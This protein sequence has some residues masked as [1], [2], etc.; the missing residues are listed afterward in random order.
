V[1]I[2]LNMM[3]PNTACKAVV[4][5][6]ILTIIMQHGES[7]DEADLIQEQA[8]SS[9][10]LRSGANTLNLIEKDAMRKAG[11]EMQPESGRS[12]FLKTGISVS[13]S[14]EENVDTSASDL[15][16]ELVADRKQLLQRNLET[17]HL[18]E[19][20]EHESAARKVLEGVIGSRSQEQK[21]FYSYMS[22]WWRLHR[23]W[24]KRHNVRLYEKLREHRALSISTLWKPFLLRWHYVQPRLLQG[25]RYDWNK[26][27]TYRTKRFL[28][29]STKKTDKRIVAARI[30][31]VNNVCFPGLLTP[32]R[33]NKSCT[34]NKRVSARA[35]QFTVERGKFEAP[36]LTVMRAYTTYVPK[37][38][39]Q[40]SHIDTNKWTKAKPAIAFVSVQGLHW[41]ILQVLEYCDVPRS[42]IGGVGVPLP[43][44]PT[45][46]SP[47]RAYSLKLMEWKPM[48]MG[49]ELLDTGATVE[50]I[51][52]S[53]ADGKLRI[54]CVIPVSH[55]QDVDGEEVKLSAQKCSIYLRQW[56]FNLKCPVGK[57]GALA[58]KT[59]VTARDD[60]GSGNGKASITPAFQS[61]LT[62]DKNR[63]SLK[64]EKQAV[65]HIHD[66]KTNADARSSVPVVMT[67]PDKMQFTADSRYKTSRSLYFS[68]I[69]ADAQKVKDGILT[70]DPEME[71][72]FTSSPKKL[73]AQAERATVSSLSKT[74]SVPVDIS[75]SAF[76]QLDAIPSNS[77]SM[78][79]CSYFWVFL[80]AIF[81]MGYSTETGL[82]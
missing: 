25:Y 76:I 56:D 31:S 40:S 46:A 78:L 73:G 34:Y 1:K 72:H 68:F 2:K 79:M 14:F 48:T 54:S 71:A 41:Q 4:L 19:K 57:T 74:K 36:S 52:L 82:N 12:Q 55:P 58:L 62:Y 60:R 53:T 27:G 17:K 64:F 29:K 81:A 80:M 11:F 32:S 63:V 45:T 18:N 35:A 39:M 23:R 8:E 3:L 26:D 28:M 67:Q 9:T 16:E 22:R 24:M 33:R 49:R 69:V 20:A 15:E 51:E 13:K 61:Q 70:W 30:R 38:R 66:D 50:N 37:S 6:I 43:F 10:T 47:T 42:T 5:A 77:A 59:Q 75:P 44:S 7:R 21:Q 65:L